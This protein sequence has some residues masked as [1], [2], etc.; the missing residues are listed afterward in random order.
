MTTKSRINKNLK[1]RELRKPKRKSLFLFGTAT[2][3]ILGLGIFYFFKVGNRYVPQTNT[4]SWQEHDAGKYDVLVQ[5]WNKY[6]IQSNVDE[7]FYLREFDVD[8]TILR[9]NEILK[10]FFT[11]IPEEVDLEFSMI[12]QQNKYSFFNFYHDFLTQYNSNSP[13][14]ISPDMSSLEIKSIIYKVTKLSD[15]NPQTITIVASMHSPCYYFYRIKDELYLKG[16][17]RRIDTCKDLALDGNKYPHL[18]A[19]LGQVVKIKNKGIN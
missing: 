4:L 6:A 18:N 17:D 13:V 3:V 7:K 5:V 12:R 2:A 14:H 15:L 9:L 16:L 10:P 11:K 19:F 1:K 8:D